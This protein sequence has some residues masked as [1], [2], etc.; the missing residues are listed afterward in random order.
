[1]SAPFWSI[2]AAPDFTNCDM[3]NDPAVHVREAPHDHLRD[4]GMAAGRPHLPELLAAQSG[5]GAGRRPGRDRIP[6]AATVDRFNERAEEVLVLYP[7]DGYWRARPLPPGNLRW[8]AYGSSF[9]IGPVET[10][11][12]PF[13]DIRDV[14]F[15]PE[16]STFTLEFRARRQRDACASTSSTRNASC[17]MWP[18][19]R[20]SPR[21]GRLRRCARCS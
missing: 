18:R 5:A 21:T 20:R 13:V 4:R 1:M 11:G 9:L 19:A 8:S 10:S 12:R 7:A 17:S 14:A 3:S 16:T 2:A 6:S 15:D